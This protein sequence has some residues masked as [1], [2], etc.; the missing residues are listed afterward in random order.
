MKENQTF[1]KARKE[2]KELCEK[3]DFDSISVTDISKACGFSRQNFY[4]NFTGKDELVKMIFMSDMK[5]ALSK[6][7]IYRFGKSSVNI[8]EALL[9]NRRFY[10]NVL[11]SS[12]GE[13][14]CRLFFEYGCIMFR[15]FAEYSAYR[16]LSYA[17]ENSLHF[18][19]SGIVTIF[20]RL[21]SGSEKMSAEEFS[22]LI[23]E[24]VPSQLKMF[25]T[26]D[27]ITADYI[28]YKTQKNMK[29]Y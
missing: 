28:L 22:K 25:I 24:S 15:S 20:L 4:K 3:Q 6:D 19:V 16:N 1:K 9:Q 23:F 2:L 14:L 29:D 11:H 17:Q 13:Y 8:T 27:G 5:K 26:D 7:D 10:L 21:L 18:Y 12:G